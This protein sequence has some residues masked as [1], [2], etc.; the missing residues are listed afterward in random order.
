MAS[1]EELDHIQKLTNAKRLSLKI[2][3]NETDSKQEGIDSMSPHTESMTQETDLME[4]ELTSMESTVDNIPPH[5][6]TMDDWAEIIP[7]GTRSKVNFT[8]SISSQTNI[9]FQE[10]MVHYQNKFSYGRV[11]KH[12]VLQMVIDEV[13]ERMKRQGLL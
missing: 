8:V 10:I 7:E 12:M 1:T 13:H 4:F 9:K 5:L 11:Y 6:R 3:G 2:V